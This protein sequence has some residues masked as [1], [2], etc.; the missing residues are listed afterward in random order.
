GGDGEDRIADRAR[1]PDQADPRFHAPRV[2]RA[3]SNYPLPQSGRGRGPSRLA[4]WEGEGFTHGAVR[5]ALTRRA[6]GARRPLPHAGAVRMLLPA[7]EQPRRAHAA[8]DAHGDDDVLRLAAA[9]FDQGVA[10]AACAGHAVGVAD[11]DRA[12]V[13]V[14]LVVG[15]AE[16]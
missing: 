4:R 9:A 10:G 15:D 8:A 11:R 1:L 13:D 5:E 14:Q 7:L 12:A 3:L 16:L 2:A 6:Q